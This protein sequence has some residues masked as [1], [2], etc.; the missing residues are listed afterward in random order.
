MMREKE[1][2]TFKSKHVQLFFP[3]FSILT[4]WNFKFMKRTIFWL[5]SFLEYGKENNQILL[6]N[7]Q[8]HMIQ[9]L[10][11]K[12]WFRVPFLVETHKSKILVWQW[13][14]R[15]AVETAFFCFLVCSK[16]LFFTSFFFF[17]FN[18]PFFPHLFLHILTSF[19]KW[20]CLVGLSPN[21]SADSGAVWLPR[22]LFNIQGIQPR[23]K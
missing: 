12:F 13:R 10:I 22:K 17:P 14:T 20:A 16:H 5:R 2:E 6:T 21:F 23:N 1:N 18:P 3:L 15:R 11:I 8:T 7:S 9:L 19:P 4:K